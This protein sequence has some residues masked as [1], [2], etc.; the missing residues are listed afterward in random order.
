MSHCVYE[1]GLIALQAYLS[2]SAEPLRA[3]IR[4]VF[5]GIPNNVG[6]VAAA[7]IARYILLTS[8]GGS[9]QGVCQRE[10]LPRICHCCTM[11]SQFAPRLF[12][13]HSGIYHGRVSVADLLGLLL[14][15]PHGR[16]DDGA[17][18]RHT[19]WI[20]KTFIRYM[21]TANHAW[22]WSCRLAVELLA[23]S[24]CLANSPRRICPACP[25][26]LDASPAS[27]C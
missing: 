19:L 26:V 15:C 1:L 4:A 10:H 21:A 7:T 11:S 6:T 12:S 3:W 13:Y 27:L 22:S 23:S 25:W 14:G 9:M 18:L 17:E 8:H 20:G 5:A 16:I 24:P 2:S